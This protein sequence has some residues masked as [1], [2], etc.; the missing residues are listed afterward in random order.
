M[1]RFLRLVDK[2]I[3]PGKIGQRLNPNI[4]PNNLWYRKHLDRNFDVVFLGD[5]AKINRIKIPD[6]IKAFD[7]S[8]EGQNLQWDFN[9]VRHFFSILKP[10]GLVVFPLIDSFVEDLNRHVD[11][12]RY[13]MPMMPYFFSQSKM[14][15]TFIRV[16]RRIPLLAMLPMFNY[17]IGGGDSGKTDLRANDLITQICDFLEE[18]DLKPC[19]FLISSKNADNE[20]NLSLFKGKRCYLKVLSCVEDYNWKTIEH[21]LNNGNG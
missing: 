16:C 18:R 14:K 11:E 15:M 4:Y 6:N 20:R 1:R 7:W 5:A 10:N 2:Y 9:V 12:R 19:F 17:G 8:L 21:F 3:K 13:Y